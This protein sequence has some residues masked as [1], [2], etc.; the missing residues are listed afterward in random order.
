MPAKGMDTIDTQL[1]SR[2]TEAS[3]TVN[4][5]PIYGDADRAAGAALLETEAAALVRLAATL[6]DRF[7]AALDAL[8]G[9]TGRVVVTGIGKSG[10]IANKIASTFASTGTPAFFVHPSEASH[11]DLGMVTAGDVV[12][13]FSNSGGSTELADLVAHTRRFENTLIAVTAN[14]SAPLAEQA[15]IV[16]LLPPEPEACPMGL[17][18]TT[19]TTM[20]LALGDALAIALLNRRGFSREDFRVLHP[21]GRLG[22]HLV[23]VADIMHSGEAVP[24]AHAGERMSDAILTMTA[25]SFGCV[26]IVDDGGA[27]CGVVTDG[28]LRRHMAGD[29]LLR[30]VS[31]VMTRHPRTIR[32]GALAVEAVTEMNRLPTPITSLFIV[33]EGMRPVGILHIHDCLRAGLA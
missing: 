26:G 8:A 5:G 30:R 32:P 27:L 11:G 16:L 20:M 14:D 28:D 4:G 18:P 6:D 1:G 12:L 10:H 23:K 17:A 24:L 31:D 22:R 9:T 21:G 33:D 13:M 2:E 3:I 19:S 29:L 25:K 7:T 15:D